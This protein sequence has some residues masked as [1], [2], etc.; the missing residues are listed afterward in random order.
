MFEKRI[1]IRKTV[2]IQIYHLLRLDYR[3]VHRR[4]IYQ[5]LY[6]KENHFA[7]FGAYYFLFE[8]YRK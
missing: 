8:L 6:K 4:S 2:H 1:R 7:W 5:R 3:Y